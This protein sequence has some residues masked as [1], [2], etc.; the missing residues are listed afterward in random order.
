MIDCAGMVA[1]GIV[2]KLKR[3]KLIKTHSET[4]K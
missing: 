4:R 3:L 1:K 2:P